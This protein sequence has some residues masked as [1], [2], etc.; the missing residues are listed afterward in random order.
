MKLINEVT[1]KGLVL[2]NEQEVKLRKAIDA[3]DVTDGY[4]YLLVWNEITDIDG[5]IVLDEG[6]FKNCISTI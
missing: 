3:G 1:S 6:G 5:D 2:S 4:G